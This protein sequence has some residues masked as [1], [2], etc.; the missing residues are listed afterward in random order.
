LKK[1][2]LARALI[3]NGA[4]AAQGT[5]GR[6]KLKFGGLEATRWLRWL[7]E[8]KDA[9]VNPRGSSVEDGRRRSGLSAVSSWS[10]KNGRGNFLPVND[11]RFFL[12]SC[13]TLGFH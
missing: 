5:G 10:G 3:E 11:G 6:E 7:E 13:V 8:H 12:V 4:G 9:S 1:R 2:W